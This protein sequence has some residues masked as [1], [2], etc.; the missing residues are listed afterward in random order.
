[1][2][3]FAHHGGTAMNDTT[4]LPPPDLSPDVLY[5]AEVK[6]LSP[7]LSD[8]LALARRAF[9]TARLNVALRKN[10][11]PPYEN[12]LVIEV[13]LDSPP[14]EERFTAERNCWHEGLRK[15]CPKPLRSEI[16]LSYL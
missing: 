14:D 2:I 11:D 7:Y 16:R 4:P 13:K 9:A 1:M 10:H 8:I 15:V 12:E 5:F 6:G 3:A